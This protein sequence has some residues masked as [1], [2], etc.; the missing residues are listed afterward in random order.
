[1]K[2]EVT[3]SKVSSTVFPGS[4]FLVDHD[5]MKKVR[6]DR[7]NLRHD[8]PMSRKAEGSPAHAVLLSVEEE[9]CRALS[10]GVVCIQEIRGMLHPLREAVQETRHV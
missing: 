6:P 1:M 3:V 9:V 5:T 7:L 2:Q 4:R 8:S 10:A